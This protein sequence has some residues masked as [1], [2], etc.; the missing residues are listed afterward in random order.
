M[1]TIRLLSDRWVSQKL[2]PS[3][4][5]KK[6]VAGTCPATTVLY[7]TR[8]DYR[9]ACAFAAAMSVS[10]RNAM[11]VTLRVRNDGSTTCILPSFS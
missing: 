2:N 1:A 4:A 7:E 9:T 8:R 11:T 6:P 3:Y 10:L 5:P